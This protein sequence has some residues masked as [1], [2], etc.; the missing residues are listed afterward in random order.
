[1][2]VITVFPLDFPC[3]C[4]STSYFPR[5]LFSLPLFLFQDKHHKDEHH[6]NEHQNDVHHIPEHREEGGNERHPTSLEPT[7]HPIKEHN[8]NDRF[9]DHH[10]DRIRG[11]NDRQDGDFHGPPRPT[12]VDQSYRRSVSADQSC[13]RDSRSPPGLRQEGPQPPP[14]MLQ[15]QQQQREKHQQ[16]GVD[17]D[18]GDGGGVDDRVG[19]EKHGHKRKSSRRGRKSDQKDKV[20]RCIFA[21]VHVCVGYVVLFPKRSCVFVATV[22]WFMSIWSIFASSEATSAPPP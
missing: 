4:V 20:C 17:D 1:M 21:H 7:P 19:D 11:S 22:F 3:T 12:P 18:G 6:R 9:N 5:S 2:L 16:F 13:R 8:N 10:P 15:R 14:E